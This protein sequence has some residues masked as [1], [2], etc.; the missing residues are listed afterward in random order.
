MP[1]ETATPQTP[2]PD[3]DLAKGAVEGPPDDHT[4]GNR[5]APGLDE[6]GLPNDEVAIGQDVIGANVD[7]SEGG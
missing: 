7:E 6:N 4:N 1:E 3:P 5:N 2:P